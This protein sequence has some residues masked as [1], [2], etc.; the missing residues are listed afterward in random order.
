MLSKFMLLSSTLLASVLAAATIEARQSTKTPPYTQLA[1]TVTDFS[2]GGNEGNFFNFTVTDG[3]D[4]LPAT[5]TNQCTQQTLQGV[6]FQNV[7]CGDGNGDIWFSYDYYN[8]GTLSIL[9]AY[10]SGTAVHDPYNFFE[11]SIVDRGE[12]RNFTVNAVQVGPEH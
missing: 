2:I 9:H 6:N 3:T 7:T 5:F 1:W 12:L 11:A 4:S 10:K 8:Q